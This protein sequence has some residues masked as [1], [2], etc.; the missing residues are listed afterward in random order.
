M[1]QAQGA[2]MDKVAAALGAP[3]DA[4]VTDPEAATATMIGLL[5][6]I[7][8]ELQAMKAVLDTIATNT[9]T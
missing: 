6:G 9:G 4:A 8:A 2:A 3:A 5:R 7:L 1:S